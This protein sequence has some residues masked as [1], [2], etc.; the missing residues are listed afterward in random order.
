MLLKGVL[1]LALLA[2]PCIVANPICSQYQE[3]NSGD[4][5]KLQYRFC[6]T[7][8]DGDSWLDYEVKDTITYW[9]KLKPGSPFIKMGLTFNDKKLNT[10]TDFTAYRSFR[11]SFAPVA[12]V[13]GKQKVTGEFAIEF[14]DTPLRSCQLNAEL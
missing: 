5:V 2:T 11:E 10:T 3:C 12:P 9:E 7:T 1:P 8:E 13:A 6:L 14:G 4:K